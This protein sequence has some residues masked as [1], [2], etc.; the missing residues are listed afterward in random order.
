MFVQTLILL[1]TVVGTLALAYGLQ[2]S[3]LSIFLK[4]ME[5]GKR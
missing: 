5:A 2:K 4:A 1:A 3:I